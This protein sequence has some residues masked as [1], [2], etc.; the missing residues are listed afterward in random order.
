MERLPVRLNLKPS[1]VTGLCFISMFLLGFGAR[2]YGVNA[3]PFWMDEVTTIH[4]AGLPLGRMIE[5]SVFFHQF[6][7]Y[8]I[9]TSWVLPFGT[10]EFWVR[11]PAVFF[12]ALSC[13]LAYGVTRTLGGAS[14][15]LATGILMALS[16]AQVQYGQ[17]ARSYTLLICAIL[18]ALWG[19]ALLAQDPAGAARSLRKTGARPGAWAAYTL[20]TIAALNVLGVSVLWLLAANLAVFVLA[21]RREIDLRGFLENWLLAHIIIIL[22]CLPW[23]LAFKLYGQRGALG[24]LDWVP[25]VT[26]IRL[27][28]A[29]AGVYFMHV[30]SLIAVRV[31]PAGV[32]GLGLVVAMLAAGG[33]FA[34][35]RQR[36]ALTV[37]CTA[38]LVLPLSLLAISAVTPVLMPR[39]L[40]WSAAPF[41]VCAGLGLK[42]LPNRLRPAAVLVLGLFSAVNLWPYYHD[43][44]KPRWDLAAE[45]LR[46][47]LQPGD[48]LLVDDP[49][50]VSMMNIYLARKGETLSADEWTLNIQK[51]AEWREAGKRVWAI[52]G[53]VGQVDHESQAQFLSQIAPLGTPSLTKH[54][55]LEI[56]VMRFDAG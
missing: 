16:P 49:Q 4:R 3:K 24:G 45:Q 28:W 10:D 42:L 48:L 51:A 19:L 20:G 2:Y 9:I 18:V 31:F 13:S 21:W 54:A 7:S 6:P 43:E 38:T 8:F 26:A 1:H 32:P 50:A 35:R 53:T 44:T 5:N 37:L 46:T 15:G 11:M 36:A 12:G 39:Y 33:A 25:P 47:Q 34:L 55:G 56:L 52:Q 41:F 14:A 22:F 27:W 40:L 30:T 23:F 17:E 29:L